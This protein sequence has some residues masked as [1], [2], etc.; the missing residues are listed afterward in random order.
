[1]NRSF[2]LC[3]LIVSLFAVALAYPL[4]V[5]A[6]AERY[7]LEAIFQS[8]GSV[9]LAGEELDLFVD[10]VFQQVLATNEEGFVSAEIPSPAFHL[11]LRNSTLSLLPQ[12]VLPFATKKPS[13]SG[14]VLQVYKVLQ[15]NPETMNSAESAFFL[16]NYLPVQQYQTR[17]DLLRWQ[18]QGLLQGD[19]TRESALQLPPNTESPALSRSFA[20]ARLRFPAPGLELGFPFWSF[21]E[22]SI[23]EALS[24]D[25]AH[26]DETTSQTLTLSLFDETGSGV[27]NGY[28]TII[29]TSPSGPH[30]VG[31]QKLNASSVSIQGLPKSSFARI[32]AE[33]KG[34]ECFTPVFSL[35]PAD[36]QLPA[37]L[38]LLPR[39]RQLQGQVILRDSS[40]LKDAQIEALSADG[41]LAETV[42]DELGFF[43][44]WPLTTSPTIIRITSST[45]SQKGSVL[46]E[47]RLFLELS[48]DSRD[49]LIPFDYLE[50]DEGFNP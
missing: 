46:Y 20:V 6:E 44:F 7:E 32:Y 28:V 26:G 13:Y 43:T 22:D 36:S 47:R 14:G 38:Q 19:S 30:T 3:S 9:P 29:L 12:G 24:V 2:A 45:L 11:A 10:S 42:T 8:A 34:R 49:I 48:A 40:P 5:C 4:R 31:R 21:S 50:L 15:S 18:N 39:E 1:M 23:S 37:Q 27:D 41:V 17:S 16:K 33:S 35:D 25:A